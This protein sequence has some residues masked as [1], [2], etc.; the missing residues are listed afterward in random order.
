MLYPLSYGGQA[1]TKVSASRLGLTKTSN[2]S[3]LVTPRPWLR[4]VCTG[5]AP[6]LP[7]MSSRAAG[8]RART[9][10]VAAA[11]VA[12][13]GGCVSQSPPE[14][15][16]IRDTAPPWPAPRDAV[17]Y[18]RQAGLAE[19]PLN[20]TSNPWVFDLTI[21]LDEQRVTVPANV[22]VDRP[23]AVQAAV[24]TH[25]D[26][27]KVWLEGEGN[28]TVTLGQLFTVW[29]VRFDQRCLGHACRNLAVRV[30]D[31]LVTTNPQQV[32]LRG[33]KTITISV[34]TR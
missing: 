11:L 20:D 15:A 28:E 17:S 33:A 29:G 31:R 30:D 21:T 18:L 26:S 8:R 6:R 13:V 2:T 25:D 12:G 9:V 1:I 34:T 7:S 23:R 24:H 16:V 27:G 22:G 32:V 10:L 14:P 4:V 5:D 3:A 19:L